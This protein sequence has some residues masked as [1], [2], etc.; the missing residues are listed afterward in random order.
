LPCPWRQAITLFTEELA[1]LSEADQTLIM[2][3]AIC[4]YLGWPQPA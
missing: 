3:E 2:G 4:S 1:W